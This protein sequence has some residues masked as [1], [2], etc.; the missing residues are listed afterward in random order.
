M[1]LTLIV[2]AFA[3]QF[4]A[5]VVTLTVRNND[6]GEP[7]ADVRV[8][9]CRF[10][11]LLAVS[12]NPLKA[13]FSPFDFPTTQRTDATGKVVFWRHPDDTE[14][15]I[16][17]NARS[18]L[19]FDLN[20]RSIVS[21][22]NRTVFVNKMHV[23]GLGVWQEDPKQRDVRSF[24][25]HKDEQIAYIG[26]YTGNSDSKGIY[27]IRMD[28]NTGFASAL[29]LVA[30]MEN[31][32]FLASNWTGDRLYAVSESANKI[33]AYSADED[34]T[35]TLLNEAKTGAGPC[36][37]AT[38]A[39]NTLAVADYGDGSVLMWQCENDGRIGEQTSLMQNTHASKVTNSQQ[40]PRAHQV[41]FTPFSAFML[42]T[43]LGADRVYV[44]EPVGEQSSR[45]IVPHS[46]APWID[47]PPGRGP[48]HLSVSPC[49]NNLYVLN[50]LS[51]TICVYDYDLKKGLF[52]FVEEVSTLPP[53]FDGRSSAAEIV[54]RNDMVYTSNRGHDSI[55]R[56]Q[57]DR[58]TGRLTLLDCTPCGGKWPRHF[59]LMPGFPWMLVANQHSNNIALFRVAKDGA[60]TPHASLDINA[61]VCVLFP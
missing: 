56:F 35:F 27:R 17:S 7:M 61:P 28:K 60:L 24:W 4:A 29:E 8:D 10:I 15:Q 25:T 46:I 22:V 31:P 11:S 54:V 5:Q 6:T 57:R 23:F 50:E 38:G 14:Y 49:L 21:H 32:S 40:Q 26:T 12:A 55:A 59:A 2:T 9:Q 36:H 52:T 30:E 53:D 19:H 48:R 13:A 18:A 3:T 34:G 16:Y 45:R 33:V 51:N 58:K 42:V 44:Y 41:T 39:G 37:V 43:D 20:G 1:W 47:L